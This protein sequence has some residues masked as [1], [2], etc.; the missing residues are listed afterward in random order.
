MASKALLKRALLFQEAK[1]FPAAINDFNKIIADYRASTETETALL[2]KGLTLGQQG[3]YPQMTTT[4]RQLLKD[5]PNGSGTA[6]ANYWIGWAAFEAKRYQDA[7][8]PLIQGAP[9]QSG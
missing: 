7:I 4:F 8:A 5:Y 9:T 1:N 6:Q 2:Q 3:D